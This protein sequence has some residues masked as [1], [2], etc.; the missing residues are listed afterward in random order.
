MLHTRCGRVVLHL[1]FVMMTFVSGM[2]IQ[3]RNQRV[4]TRRSARPATRLA[5]WPVGW[6]LHVPAALPFTFTKVKWM[7]PG[8]LCCAA[9]R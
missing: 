9:W 1:L 5:G 7:F 8:M 6:L 4:V 2:L 3:C